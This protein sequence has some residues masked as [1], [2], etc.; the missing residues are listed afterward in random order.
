MTRR[1]SRA[2]P[3]AVLLAVTL[4]GLTGCLLAVALA[5]FQ[6]WLGLQLAADNGAGLRIVSLAAGSPAARQPEL[7]APGLRLLAISGQALQSEDLIEEPD[8]FSRYTDMAAFF[9]RQSGIASRLA[10]PTVTLSVAQ[11][12]AAP[13]ESTELNLQPAGHRPVAELPAMFWFQLGCGLAGLMI[14]AWIWTLRRN[15]WSARMFA[16]TGVTCAM[17]AISAAVY[18]CRELAIDGTS[19][20]LLSAINHTGTLSFGM[21]LIAMFLNFPHRLVAPRWLLVI[22][23]IFVPWL[24]ADLLQLAPDLDLG[25]R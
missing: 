13:G 12:G 22:P 21:A 9:E 8:F 11:A 6:P 5:V 3:G 4:A 2:S 7:A 17:A 15:D 1:R 23:V 24:L 20:R 10:A 19:F 18:S 16:L 25:L 14:A